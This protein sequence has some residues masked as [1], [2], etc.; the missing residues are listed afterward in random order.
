[1]VFF[2]TGGDGDVARGKA[3]AVV[4]ECNGGSGKEVPLKERQD[5]KQ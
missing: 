3:V 4:V 2:G 1:M 5:M